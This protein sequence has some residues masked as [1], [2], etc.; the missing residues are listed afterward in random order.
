[1]VVLLLHRVPA[2]R[3]NSLLA[4]LLPQPVTSQWAT[5]RT[6]DATPNLLGLKDEAVTVA[7]FL[8]KPVRAFILCTSIKNHPK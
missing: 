1:M 3:F 5:E 6:K 8:R 4:N 7:S 2:V